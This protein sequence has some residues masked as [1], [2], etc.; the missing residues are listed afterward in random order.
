MSLRRFFVMASLVA[1]ATAAAPAKA[2]ADWLFT[3]FVGATFGGS[4][5]IAGAGDSFSDNFDR[6]GT[7]GASLEWMG[8]GVLGF[9][10]D[11][12]Y[13]PN[14]FRNSDTGEFG[15]GNVTTVMANV[16]VGAPIGGV[17]PYASGGVGL[18]KQKVD[19]VGQF[20]DT[21]D[22]TD[23]GMNVGGGVMGFFTDNVG[24]RG[25]IRYFRSLQDSDPDGIDLNLGSFK[26]WRGSVGVTFKF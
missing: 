21:I 19:D 11:F 20:F 15:D 25:D 12:G 5:D 16:I 9:G 22:S 18:M 13:T 3:P 23:F 17:R 10:V 4:A 2:S 7:Y 1:V 6:R 14:F 26:F 24:I 8:A